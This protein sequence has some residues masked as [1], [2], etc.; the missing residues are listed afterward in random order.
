MAMPAKA[1][2]TAPPRPTAP[3][4]PRPRPAR[5][6]PPRATQDRARSKAMARATVRAKVPGNRPA[7]TM[8]LLARARIRAIRATARNPDLLVAKSPKGCPRA[9]FRAF[10]YHA[11]IV[12]NDIIGYQ[13]LSGKV[14]DGSRIP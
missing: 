1:K 2:L 3:A 7:L 11:M 6:S 13:Q 14:L 10:G 12:A 9:A 8:P 4:R 5:A